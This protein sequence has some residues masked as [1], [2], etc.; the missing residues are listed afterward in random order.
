MKVVAIFL[1]LAAA[2]NAA[3]VASPLDLI[4]NLQV[5]FNFLFNTNFTLQCKLYWV[6]LFCHNPTYIRSCWSTQRQLESG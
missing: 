3:S 5:L 1:A 4:D 2:T 6:S